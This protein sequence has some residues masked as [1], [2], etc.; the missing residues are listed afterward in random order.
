M[1]LA[2]AKS[3][4]R[5]RLTRARRE[6]VAAMSL[7]YVLDDPLDRSERGWQEKLPGEESWY[8]QLRDG[9]DCEAEPVGWATVHRIPFGH[10]RDIV[11][12]LDSGYDVD[13]NAVLPLV[14]FDMPKPAL[15]RYLTIEDAWSGQG[16]LL[17]ENLVVT[18]PWWGLGVA[19]LLA[20]TALS[21]LRVSDDLFV[22]AY[23]VPWHVQGQARTKLGGKV[24]PVYTRLGFRPYRHGVWL[25]TRAPDDQLPMLRARFGLRDGFPLLDDCLG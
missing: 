23:P 3:E 25:R 12:S 20:A 16:F 15:L 13:A 10:G 22:A 5:R 24:R 18:E 6:R 9:D 2:A 4:P 19:E 8:V 1:T 11:D 17:L 7:R 14:D 21:R